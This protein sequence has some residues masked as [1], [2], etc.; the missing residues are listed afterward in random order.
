MSSAMR[1][2]AVVADIIFRASAR[3]RKDQCFEIGALLRCVKPR[4]PACPGHPFDWLPDFSRCGT[5]LRL[6]QSAPV[7]H[8]PTLEITGA[9]G[10]LEHGSSRDKAFAGFASL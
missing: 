10:A 4:G 2:C 9:T 7:L 5:L 8:R 3:P 6:L 1:S